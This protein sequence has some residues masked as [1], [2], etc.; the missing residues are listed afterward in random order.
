MRKARSFLLKE[1]RSIR[2]LETMVRSE[3]SV[4]VPCECSGSK[5]DPFLL[6]V[7]LARRGFTEQKHFLQALH[8]ILRSE[9]SVVFL[10]KVTFGKICAFW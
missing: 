1:K 9:R 4:T 8:H 6:K 5:D 3:R 7:Y 2:T 10:E